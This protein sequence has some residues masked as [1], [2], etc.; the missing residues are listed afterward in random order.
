MTSI[1]NICV[2]CGASNRVSERYMLAAQEV[3]KLLAT[4]GLGLVYGGGRMGLMGMVAD[5]VLDNGGKAIGVI[6]KHLQDREVRHEKLSELYVVDT[7]HIRKQMMA[8]RSDAFLILPGGYGTL[9]EAFEMLTWKQLGLH[10][11]PIVFLNIFDFWTP[12]QELKQHLSDESFIKQDDLKLFSL[13]ESP[14]Q[15]IAAIQAQISA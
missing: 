9:E 13:V 15:I 6:P 4:N 7:M 3:G 14:D 10:N 2:Y 11:K 1:K 8:E 12:L 5:S